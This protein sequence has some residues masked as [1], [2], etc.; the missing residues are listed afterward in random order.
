MEVQVNALGVLLAAV[1]SM[2]VGSVW[3]A[4]PVLGDTWMK[5]AKVKMNN[6][7]NKMWMLLGLTFLL[8]LLT[9]Y[10]LAHVTYLSSKFFGDSYLQSAL[11]TAFWAWLGFTAARIYT[12][13]LFEGRPQK[14]TLITVSHE[15]FTF[16]VMGLVIGLVG[17]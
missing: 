3:Y 2:A 14:L 4:K 1:A 6:D 13:D 17:V 11:T 10:I 8:A 7:K 9:A 16:L 5:L 12:H 15:L